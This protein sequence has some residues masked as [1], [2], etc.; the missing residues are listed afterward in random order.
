MFVPPFQLSGV[1][2]VRKEGWLSRGWVTR[3]P[4]L[5]LFG[6]GGLEPMSWW[7]RE[8]RKNYRPINYP[9]GLLD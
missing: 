1:I 6:F 4:K 3:K 9:S 2:I 8:G 7:E 5:P